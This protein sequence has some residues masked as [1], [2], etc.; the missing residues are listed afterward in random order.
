[1]IIVLAAISLFLFPEKSQQNISLCDEAQ[2]SEI[3]VASFNIQ[4]FGKT[5]REKEDV[6]QVLKKIVQEFDIVFI[7]EL[8]DA[9]EE[10]AS[11]FLDEIN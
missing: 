8:R 2:K 1:M 6:M 7:Q 9:K 5:K 3:K 4:V 11:Y 10:T